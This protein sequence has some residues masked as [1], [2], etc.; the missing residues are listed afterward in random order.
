[1]KGAGI[2]AT[3]VGLAVVAGIILARNPGEFTRPT[4]ESPPPERPP[5]QGFVE[6]ALGLRLLQPPPALETAGKDVLRTQVHKSFN[7]QFGPGGLMY[8]AR[9]WELLGFNDWT[10]R[11]LMH[12]LFSLEVA[13]RLSWFDHEEDRLLVADNFDEK[14]NL[15]DKMDLHGLLTR[16]L[17]KQHTPKTI[18]RLSDDA[19]V[20]Q[21]IL[22][23]SIVASVEAKFREEHP[24]AFKLPSA[25]LTERESVKSIL[26]SFLFQLGAA[27]SGK[28]IGR[29]YLETRITTGARALGDLIRDPPNSTLELYGGDPNSIAPPSF[30]AALSADPQAAQQVHLEESLGAFGVA[31]LCEYLHVEY[32]QLLVLARLWRGDRYRLFS[33][34]A[35]DH[36][37]WLTN[38]E[39]PQ[40]AARAAHVIGTDQPPAGSDRLVSISVHGTVTAFV[41]CADP[42]TL[43][44]ITTVLADSTF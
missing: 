16:L 36:I 30:P 39:T 29:V 40:A 34:S 9:A 10:G 17:I 24:E 21:K 41:N 14:K 33:N 38:W 3:L 43:E 7:A 15:E 13:G 8:R 27:S 12:E 11:D 6:D 20:A 37:I 42:A 22:T 4:P 19:W 23:D 25:R 28:E 2:L 1:M 31:S 32:A 44:Q 35:G 5:I 18:G 26:P